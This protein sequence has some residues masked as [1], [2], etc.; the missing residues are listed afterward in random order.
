VNRLQVL[1]LGR[2]RVDRTLLV[3][4]AA[5]GAVDIPVAAYAVSH[6]GGLLLFDTGCHPLA[7]GPT[8]RWAPAFQAA[9]PWSGDDACHLTAA[10]AARGLA[11]DDFSDVV[12]S[13]LHSDHAGC[14]EFFGRARLIVHADE[15]AAAR[16]AAA[17]GEAE[18]GYCPADIARWHGLHWRPVARDAPDFDLAPGV[19]VLNLG[20]GHAAGM[21][22]LLVRLAG[23]GAVILASDAAYC[24]ANFAP[25]FRR[26]GFL[27]DP[28]GS[29]R[30]VRR[31]ARLAGQTGARVWF[32]HDA[33]QFATLRRAADDWYA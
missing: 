3:A 4:D 7:M 18:G 32:G 24:A 28:A 8:G 9:Y 19:R 16:Q 12:L 10:L 25:A 1:D 13:H 26:P 2:M 17:A 14:V 30:T 6:P 15:L 33:D 31:L 23:A 11:P 22:A 20:S 21:L 27:R 5:P 29:D